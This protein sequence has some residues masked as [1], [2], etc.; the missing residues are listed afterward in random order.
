MRFP[1]AV[2]LGNPGRPRPMGR[3]PIIVSGRTG[4]VRSWRLGLSEATPMELPFR[5][6]PAADTIYEQATAY[7]RFTPSE[8]L[9]VL[10]DLIASGM[11][12]LQHAPHRQ[13]RQRLQ[14]EYEAEWQRVQKEL[15]AR[16]GR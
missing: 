5:F 9:R 2:P 16:H 7:R 14:E 15:F 8:R 3:I 4:S 6:P 13:A 1:A 12:L 10:L 11:A